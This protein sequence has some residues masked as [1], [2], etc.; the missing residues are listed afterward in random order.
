M[1]FHD[2]YILLNMAGKKDKIKDSERYTIM[3]SE[4][5]GK[6]FICGSDDRVAKHEIFFGPNRNK[7]KED[8]LVVELCWNHHNGS[9]AGVH[10]NHDLDLN[11]KKQ[12]EKIWIMNY[13]KSCDSIDEKINKFIKRFG[14]NYLIDDMD[15]PHD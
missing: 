4:F 1:S 2:W 15:L 9:N 10:Y 7:S 11:L 5:T 14:K 3:Q 13:T 8:G 12:A 6:C